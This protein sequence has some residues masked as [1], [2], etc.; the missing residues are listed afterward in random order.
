MSSLRDIFFEGRWTVDSAGARTCAPA[1]SFRFAFEG[2][3]AEVE[4]EGAAR[5]KVSVDGR[6]FPE[7]L[8]GVRKM[9]RIGD[10]LDDARH[11]AV[12]SKKTE[13]EFGCVH[14][15]SVFAPAV[16][17]SKVTPKPFRFEFIGD[18]YTVGFGNMAESPVSGDAFSTTD[19]TAG[20][21]SLL[22]EKWNAELA[23][24]AYSGRGLVQNYMGMAPRWTIPELIRWT[25]GGEAPLG[26]SPLW[27]FSFIPD[28]VCLFLGINDWQGECP[29]PRPDAFDRA[30][31]ELLDFLRERYGGRPHFVLIS[32]DVFPDNLLPER[33]ESVFDKEISRGMRDVSTVFLDTERNSGLDFHPGLSRHR[34]M[35]AELS[36]IF[37]EVLRRRK[38]F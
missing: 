18:S 14:L 21:G 17:P 5:W 35:A 22:A 34:Q 2:T 31:A 3:F 23:V 20:Y 24:N 15:H 25:L 11:E 33:V 10:F 9:Y 28:V 37:S 13:T 32:T 27:D 36:R 29:H 7:L 16:F 26:N 4:L 1:A 38:S 19:A 12:L 30:Y 8:T 6:E